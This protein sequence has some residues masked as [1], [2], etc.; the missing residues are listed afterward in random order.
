[1][2]VLVVVAVKPTGAK[3]LFGYMLW[4]IK[5][6]KDAFLMLENFRITLQHAKL[7]TIIKHSVLKKMKRML[8]KLPYKSG[9][10]HHK[11]DEY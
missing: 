2:G 3:T 5:I 6:K 7:L 4:E 10:M 8:K 11:K 9:S 1:M